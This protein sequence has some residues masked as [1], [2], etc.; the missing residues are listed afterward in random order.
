MNLK[1][2]FLLGSLALIGKAT[3]TTNHP[4]VPELR[5]NANSLPSDTVSLTA[6]GDAGVWL[7]VYHSGDCNSGYEAQP[8]SGWV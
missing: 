1:T 6:R 4:P 8:V 3:P 7:D 2:I 5:S